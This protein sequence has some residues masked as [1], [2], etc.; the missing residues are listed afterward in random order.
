MKIQELTK[1]SVDLVILE[2]SLILFFRPSFLHIT[3]P[4]DDNDV[5][6]IICTR[7]FNEKTVHERILMVYN[8]I[9]K[10]C[11]NVLKDRL[12]VVQAFNPTEMDEVLE[13]VFDS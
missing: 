10:Q 1:P 7:H 9:K 2:K 8:T 11:P 6:V 12:V 3:N 13:Y 5:Q 4:D